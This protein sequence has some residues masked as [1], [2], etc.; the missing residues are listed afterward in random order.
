MGKCS[1]SKTL[2]RNMIRSLL[3]NESTFKQ[4]A[5]RLNQEISIRFVKLSSQVESKVST[6]NGETNPLNPLLAP[7]TAHCTLPHHYSTEFTFDVVD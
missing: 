6:A 3:E 5:S 7:M 1:T 4:I 2:H